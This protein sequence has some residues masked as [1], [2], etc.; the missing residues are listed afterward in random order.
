VLWVLAGNVRAERF[1][2]LDHWT[3]DGHR[4]SDEVWGV[5]V[6]ELRYQRTL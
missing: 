2:R 1:Y 3:A 5:A 4:R 6:N